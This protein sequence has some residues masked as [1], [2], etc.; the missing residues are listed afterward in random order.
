[1]RPGG[2]GQ[3]GRAP[4]EGPPPHQPPSPSSPPVWHEGPSPDSPDGATAIIGPPSPRPH[5]SA[6]ALNSSPSNSEPSAPGGG[7]CCVTRPSSLNSG[8]GMS[9]PCS[10]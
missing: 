6:A 4:R 1:R 3:D 9:I 7:P 5:S 10:R 2:G 8:A